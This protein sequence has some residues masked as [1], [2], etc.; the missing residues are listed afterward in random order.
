WA[1][2]DLE[3]AYQSYGEG[4]A[5]V[6]RDGHLSA[7][8]GRAVTLADIRVAQGRLRDAMR[9]YEQALQIAS[10]QG[11]AVVR[12]T[13]DMHVGISEL[14]RER[15][16]LEAA[17]GS[18]LRSRELSEQSGFA[19]NRYRWRVAM[20]RI[21]EARGDFHGAPCW[22]AARWLRQQHSWIGCSRQRKTGAGPEA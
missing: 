14:Q 7:T 15:N 9:T 20:A 12:G 19:Q 1:S 18:L 21:H 8:V 3:T 2:G 6:Q 4:M 5:D 22:P 11:G 16:E 17:T 13:A 10:E